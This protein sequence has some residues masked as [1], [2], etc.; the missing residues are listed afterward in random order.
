MRNIIPYLEGAHVND[1]TS[2]PTTS[3]VLFVTASPRNDS[4]SVH[5]A[6]AFLDS[7]RSVL[8]NTE[9]DRLNTFTDLPT[10][11]AQHVSA[12]MEIGRA[13]V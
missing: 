9:V 2:A 12:K 1:S 7:Y 5:L 8:P 4:H 10:F 13:H 3:R 11:D 6:E